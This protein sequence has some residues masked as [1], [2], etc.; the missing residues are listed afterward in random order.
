M[1]L[2]LWLG[3]ENEGIGSIATA[4]GEFP[5][6]GEKICKRTFQEGDSRLDSWLAC[7]GEGL[8]GCRVAGASSGREHRPTGQAQLAT[9]DPMQSAHQ[10]FFPLGA[11]LDS[12]RAEVRWIRSS[13]LYF[14]YPSIGLNN[15]WIHP[16]DL[17]EGKVE[18]FPVCRRRTRS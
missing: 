2:N 13:G 17:A 1:F 7:C 4:S 12:A 8:V 14:G 15:A 9:F 16:N 5:I 18:S 11:D 3:F 6:L 10:N